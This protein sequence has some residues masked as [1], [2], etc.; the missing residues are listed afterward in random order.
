MPAPTIEEI[1][2]VTIAAHERG[3]FSRRSTVATESPDALEAVRG[4]DGV[5]T[6]EE[7]TRA[8]PVES[9]EHNV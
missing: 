4:A 6:C 8:S 2:R 3:A 1:M 7:M 5:W 9:G